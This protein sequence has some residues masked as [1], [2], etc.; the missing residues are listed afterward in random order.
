MPQW[1]HQ[2]CY[3]RLVPRH[4]HILPDAKQT[5]TRLQHSVQGQEETLHTCRLQGGWAG[6]PR[7]F[8]IYI[9]NQML[10]YKGKKVK[11]NKLLRHFLVHLISC[12]VR[13]LICLCMK[14]NITNIGRE[15]GSPIV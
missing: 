9:C 8:A 3:A 7:R 6:V 2:L 11:K 5:G 1:L 14:R 10:S 15:D 4:A 12:S 13:R